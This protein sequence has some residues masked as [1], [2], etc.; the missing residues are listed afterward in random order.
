MPAHTFEE[1]FRERQRKP[2][3]EE[4]VRPLPAVVFHTPKPRCKKKGGHK[5][6]ECGLWK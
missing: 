2:D 4:P 6:S 3:P 5:P 1:I